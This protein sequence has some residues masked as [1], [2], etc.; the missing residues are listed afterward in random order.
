MGHFVFSFSAFFLEFR[1]GGFCII[2]VFFR[3]SPG[4]RGFLGSV[5][6]PQDRKLWVCCSPG[7]F[8]QWG[9]LKFSEAQVFV[10]EL[11]II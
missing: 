10:R 6:P 7:L 11:G 2:F 5:P 8:K 4:F 1:G 3:S 9:P